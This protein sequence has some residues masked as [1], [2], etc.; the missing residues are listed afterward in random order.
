MC[1]IW[2][3]YTYSK[4]Q[5]KRNA[6]QP[7]QQLKEGRRLYSKIVRWNGLSENVSL[8]CGED[9]VCMKGARWR[10]REG[11]SGWVGSGV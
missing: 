10:E 5:D 7:S 11:D 6:S 3:L 2:E 8:A 1:M 9:H 4:G